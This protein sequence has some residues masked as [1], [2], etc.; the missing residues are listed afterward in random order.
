MSNESPRNALARF[1]QAM[2][3]KSAAATRPLPRTS[4][5]FPGYSRHRSYLVFRYDP[6]KRRLTAHSLAGAAVPAT[7][8]MVSRAFRDPQAGAIALD[9]T[10]ANAMTALVGDDDLAL[11][12]CVAGHRAA[13]VSPRYVELAAAC[14]AR[15]WA[16]AGMDAESGD[17]W[18]AAF[19]AAPSEA[20]QVAA[21]TAAGSEQS[22]EFGSYASG[23]EALIADAMTELDSALHPGSAPGDKAWVDRNYAFELAEALREYVTCLAAC[24]PATRTRGLL[25][26]DLARAEVTGAWNSSA[27]LRL[28]APVSVKAGDDVIVMLPDGRVRPGP[29]TCALARYA[30]EGDYLYADLNQASRGSG[31]DVVRAAGE[32]AEVLI[33]NVKPPFGSVPRKAFTRW[34]GK[35]VSDRHRPP[36]KRTVPSYIVLAGGGPDVTGVP[37]T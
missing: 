34:S 32:G 29:A 35:S 23:V 11:A 37:A 8:E 3:E 18:L 28:S 9:R 21:L 27:R 15:F 19:G 2:R 16:P 24:D 31:L 26:G 30:V 1:D 6:G 13:P 5:G 33:G 10:A 14:D 25:S 7:G 20:R 12:L 17:A 22:A 4:G 36:R